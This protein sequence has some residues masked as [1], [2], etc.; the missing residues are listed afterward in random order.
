MRR[1]QD[2]GRV[3]RNLPR[4]GAA[5]HRVA[6]HRQAAQPG[7]GAGDESIITGERRL[8]QQRGD[9]LAGQAVGMVGPMGASVVV[10]PVGLAVVD[11][12]VAAEAGVQRAGVLTA[13]GGV[14]RDRAEGQHG[15]R[16]VQVPDLA[17]VELGGRHGAQGCLGGIAEALGQ[18]RVRH[19]RGKPFHPER[20]V[21]GRARREARGGVAERILFADPGIQPA[22]GRQRQI[23]GGVGTRSGQGRQPLQRHILLHGRHHRAAGATDDHGVRLERSVRLEP[24]GIEGQ[25]AALVAVLS[26]G[27]GEQQA[28]HLRPGSEPAVRRVERG[29]DV[30]VLPA[31]PHQA[32]VAIV[33]RDRHQWKSQ[34]VQAGHLAVGR[35]PVEV[36]GGTA[37]LVLQVLDSWQEGLRFVRPEVA[38]TGQQPQDR[39][40]QQLAVTV[41]RQARGHRDGP[42]WPGGEALVDLPV[43]AVRVG[44]ADADV[45]RLCRLPVRRAHRRLWLHGDAVLRSGAG[46]EPSGLTRMQITHQRPHV[47]AGHAL[48]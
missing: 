6:I 35:G 33:S 34:L 28:Q 21:R 24:D 5:R 25:E 46:S 12:P 37:R 11:Q 15:R 4:L 36:G 27:P 45:D 29:A 16:A 14:F 13:A 18:R 47:A 1:G 38:Q 20:R 3:Q 23:P 7:D 48:P 41:H 2:V 39:Q 17:L 31:A 30:A 42:G 9:H 19:S 40:V 10:A 43:G 44:G 32:D 22:L 8:A 26:V